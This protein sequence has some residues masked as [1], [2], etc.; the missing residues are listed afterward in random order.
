MKQQAIRPFHQYQRLLFLQNHKKIA[1]N[2][3]LLELHTCH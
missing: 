3:C 2:F 1:L